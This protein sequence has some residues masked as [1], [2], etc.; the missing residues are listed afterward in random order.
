MHHLER[1]QVLDGTQLVTVQEQ[2]L[3]MLEIRNADS[4]AVLIKY[5]SVSMDLP[6]RIILSDTKL[7]LTAAM[8]TL[9]VA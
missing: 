5:A 2:H 4:V 1:G 7:A 3:K 9:S 6:L 8:V